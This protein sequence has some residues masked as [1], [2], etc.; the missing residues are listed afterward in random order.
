MAMLYIDVYPR[1]ATSHNSVPLGV[2]KGRGWIARLYGRLGESPP[3]T[4]KNHYEKH[5]DVHFPAFVTSTGPI[6]ANLWC[7]QCGW[8]DEDGWWMMT[9]VWSR[10]NLPIAHLVVWYPFGEQT[11]NKHC[12]WNSPFSFKRTYIHCQKSPTILDDQKSF[13]SVHKR[14]QWF[15]NPGKKQW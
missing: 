4:L 15:T 12:N 14:F 10:W 1:L 5:P 7:A 3:G 2:S 9:A 11:W 13:S 6:G 8:N